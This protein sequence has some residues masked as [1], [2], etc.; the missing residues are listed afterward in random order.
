MNHTKFDKLAGTE[1]HV[2]RTAYD[3]STVNNVSTYHIKWFLLQRNIS[4]KT[5]GNISDI[6]ASIKST[7]SKNKFHTQ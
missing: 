6:G 5:R 2:Y 7:Y 3:H 1:I 4:Y